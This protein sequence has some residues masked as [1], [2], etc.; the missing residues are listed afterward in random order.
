MLLLI[1][2]ILLKYIGTL[3]ACRVFGTND[4]V[5]DFSFDPLLKLINILGHEHTSLTL[6]IIVLPR[7]DFLGHLVKIEG[8]LRWS[9]IKI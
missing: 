2:L 7:L 4:I 9:T 6:F 3:L 8:L 5:G 1:G